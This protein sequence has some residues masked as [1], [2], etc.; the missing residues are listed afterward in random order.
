MLPPIVLTRSTHDRLA[1]LISLLRDRGDDDLLEFVDQ[2][3]ARAD[4]VDNED[5]D[6]RIA[7]LGRQIEYSDNL[8]G[9]KAVVTLAYPTSEDSVPTGLSVLTP[10]GACILGLSEGQSKQYWTAKGLVCDIT[11]CAVLTGK[12]PTS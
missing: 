5:L 11:L 9:R 7:E 1:L 3:L 4:L 2:E 12:R 10:E 6:S 8:S